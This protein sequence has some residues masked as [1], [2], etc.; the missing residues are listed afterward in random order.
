MRMI[1]IFRRPSP[2]RPGL[3]D[4]AVADIDEQPCIATERL[5]AALGRHST[6]SG[7]AGVRGAAGR[8][9]ARATGPNI[10][11]I[12][13]RISVSG[14]SAALERGGMVVL[15]D[16][17]RALHVHLG[18]PREARLRQRMSLADVDR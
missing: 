10:E 1:S 2:G 4:D 7:G 12:L 11:E 9:R 15:R 13:A 5:V 8:I 16:V 18:G 6:V 17:P 14:G 3:P